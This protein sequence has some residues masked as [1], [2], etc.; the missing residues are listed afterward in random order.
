MRCYTFT[1]Y[2]HVLDYYKLMDLSQDVVI[3]SS[4]ITSPVITVVFN[5][6][7]KVMSVVL[8]LDPILMRSLT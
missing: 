6:L 1:M 5:L 7:L 3:N 4:S 8:Y 2:V